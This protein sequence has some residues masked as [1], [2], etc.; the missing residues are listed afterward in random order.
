MRGALTWQ[1]PCRIY[2]GG[3]S[4]SD[5]RLAAGEA[6]VEHGGEGVGAALHLRVDDSG[7]G[8]A[9]RGLPRVRRLPPG[10]A[11]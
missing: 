8:R 9:L 10:A 4:A 11:R 3:R 7:G 5:L 2:P 1:L 6:D